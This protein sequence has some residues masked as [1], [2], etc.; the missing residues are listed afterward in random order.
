MLAR[1]VPLLAA[2]LVAC[3]QPP[4][5]ELSGSNAQAMAVGTCD[6]SAHEST[7][8]S[9]TFTFDFEC[10]VDW[11]TAAGCD[12]DL[13][14]DG[15][16]SSLHSSAIEDLQNDPVNC[17]SGRA[18]T[19]CEDGDSVSTLAECTDLADI[20][21]VTGNAW[22]DLEAACPT[23]AEPDDGSCTLEGVDFT[24][25][26]AS[27]ALTF[28]EE[29]TCDECDAVLDARVCEDAIND[30]A[31]CYLGSTCTGCGDSD[32]R[33]DGVDC[34]EIAAYSYFGARAAA[35]LLSEVQTN[36][37][38]GDPSTDVTVDGVTFTEEEAAATLQVANEAT[39]D[40][41]DDDAGLNSRAANN[42]VTARPLADIE[43]LGAVSYV[44]AAA[45]NQLKTYA[46]TWP[47]PAGDTPSEVTASTLEDEGDTYGTSSV[48]YDTL[49]TVAR[50]IV[51]SE[52]SSSSSGVKIMVAA[53]REGNVEQ[54]TVYLST[55]A[56]VDTSSLSLFD[57]VSFTGTFIDYGSIFEVLLSDSS[58]DSLSIETSGLEYE[59]YGSIKA[60]WASTASNPE[61][62]VLIEA[63]FGYTYMV[64][65]PLVLDHPMWEGSPPGAPAQSGNEQDH[66]W[67][68]TAQ[69]ALDAWSG[70]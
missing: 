12:F 61:G 23:T 55:S 41:L 58:T 18:C 49:V 42:I 67:N 17:Q 53:P 11:L 63:T 26:E 24:A 37:C 33:D 22:S 35:A 13:D 68:A 44:G 9:T 21:Y 5:L 19:G 28:F 15:N 40:E 29:M 16:G 2:L 52:P 57:E 47:P 8:L 36:P 46:E 48:Y 3:G 4:D 69:D 60:A 20:A 54:L 14:P 43:A 66:A 34:D 1:H 56:G 7:S 64:P 27:C 10:A 39:L 38:S 51:T 62:V 25:D 32:S 50:A 59:D 65:L 45:L 31:T 70:S 6:S 30:S